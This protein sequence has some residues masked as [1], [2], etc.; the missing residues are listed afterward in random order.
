MKKSDDMAETADEKL[1]QPITRRLW[2]QSVAYAAAGAS[3]IGL[4]S[5]VEA[6]GQ[7][8]PLAPAIRAM[9]AVTGDQIEESWIGPTASLV[10][11]ILDYSKGLRELN[12]SEVEPATDFL[13]L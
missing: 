8:P 4:S 2:I 9:M 13:V 5:N 12:L 3:T 1:N 7:A 10:G 11:I 6:Q